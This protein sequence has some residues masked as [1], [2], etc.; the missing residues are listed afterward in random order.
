VAAIVLD[1]AVV[2]PV[3]LFRRRLGAR[4]GADQ[5]AA[6]HAPELTVDTAGPA[7]AAVLAGP[8]KLRT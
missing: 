7:P 6:P 5:S 1:M 2:K 4:T 8:T 3:D